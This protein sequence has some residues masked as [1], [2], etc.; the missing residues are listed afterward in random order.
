MN[1]SGM[2]IKMEIEN[3]KVEKEAANTIPKVVVE[4]IKNMRSGDTFNQSASYYNFSH[5]HIKWCRTI[6]D[7]LIEISI[8]NLFLIYEK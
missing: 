5:P 3:R 2:E 6:I 7:W 1:D 8:N 4:Y